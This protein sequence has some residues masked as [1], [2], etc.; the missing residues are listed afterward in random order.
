MKQRI[1]LLIPLAALLLFAS[2]EKMFLGKDPATDPLTQFEHLWRAV[3]EQYAYFELKGI[4][5]D[6]VHTVYRTRIHDNMTDQALFD[7][8]AD[9]LYVLRDGHVNL[10]SPF[11]RSRNWDWYLDYPANFNHTLVYRNY[12][13]KDYRITEPLHHTV[14]DS[15]LYVYYASFGSTISQAHLD[16]LMERASGLR[17]LI[18]DIRHNGGG[19][20][21]NADRLASALTAEKRLYGRSR[22]KTGPGHDAFS[23]WS[24]RHISPRSG[25][26]FTGPVVVLCNRNAYSTSSRFALMMHALP[27]V[28]IMGDQTGGGGGIPVFGELPNGWVYR[29]SATQMVDPAGNHIEDGVPVDIQ[30]ALDPADEASGIDTI[31]EEALKRLAGF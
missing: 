31:I 16:L 8:L 13:G 15:V 25:K 22:I 9:M 18:I 26:V 30:V 1:T 7:V 27:H 6:S 3:D 19:I 23:G 10:S 11:D 12:L 28:T 2:C 17:G 5:W 29:L 20:S 14:I 24:D 4:D 21:G